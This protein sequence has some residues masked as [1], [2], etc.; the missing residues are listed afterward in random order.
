VLRVSRRE[1]LRPLLRSD[2]RREEYMFHMVGWKGWET[3][4]F[5]RKVSLVEEGVH[6]P[7]M[8]FGTGQRKQGSG[9]GKDVRR[10]D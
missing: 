10:R 7:E 9:R 5:G 4:G 1:E 3:W 6:I 2:L 8:A